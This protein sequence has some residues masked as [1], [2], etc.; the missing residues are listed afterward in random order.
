MFTIRRRSIAALSVV[1]AATIGLSACS[2][3]SDSGGS[4]ASGASGDKVTLVVGDQVRQTQSLLEAS[5]E[6]KDLP[7]NIT[8][9]SFE[10]GPPLLEAASAGKVD[11]GGTGDVP[12]VFA[13]ASDAH[14]KI[15]AVQDRQAANDF[16][17][18]PKSSTATSIAD[19]K[20][21]SIGVAKGSSSHGLLLGLLKKAGL[22]PADVNVKYLQ[23]TEGLS[24]FQSHQIDAWAVWNPYTA[25]GVAQADGKIIGDAKGVTT[26]QSYYLASD[27]ALADSAKS[28]ALG[29]FVTRLTKALAWSGTHEDEWIP[30]FSKLTKLPAPVAKATFETSEGVLVP[31]GDAQIAQQQEL[32][33]LFH[34]AGEISSAPK[35][36]EYF[37]DRFN[38]DVSAGT[39]Q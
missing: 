28:K 1:V 7:Y 23:P 30:T 24:A 4:S 15:V 6:L 3:S 17:L 16:L 33:D 21:K 26:L 8:W 12:P 32:I 25:V 2:S 14:V 34:G 38:S 19:L 13:Q 27:A 18:V 10:S 35:A 31:I 5:G 36:A 11:I 29:D 22:T 37:D 39:A 20:G 9:S